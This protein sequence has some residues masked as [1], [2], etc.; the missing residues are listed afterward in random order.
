MTGIAEVINIKPVADAGSDVDIC[1]N[2]IS[3]LASEPKSGESGKWTA[4]GGSFINSNQY[5]TRY[6]SDEYGSFYLTWTISIDNKDCYTSDSLLVTLWQVPESFAGNDAI[7]YSDEIIL[8]AIEPSSGTGVWINIDGDCNVEKIDQHNSK[9]SGFTY[10][11]NKLEWFVSNYTF[12][13]DL[14]RDLGPTLREWLVNNSACYSS[15]T[16]T[17]TF[18]Q[19]RFPTAFSPG[20]NGFNDRFEIKGAA[21]VKN[22]MLIVFNKNGKVVF[23]KTNYG[24][25]GEFWDGKENGEYVPDGLYN[26]IFSGDGIKSV[27]NFLVIKRDEE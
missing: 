25:D 16:V 22:N 14:L 26:Y 9:A 15:D 10:G 21:Q 13:T 5:D 6:I 17:I 2:S 27:K 4:M 8:S 20:N 3:L 11:D 12:H 18:A 24:H 7:I 1:G 23:K 19:K